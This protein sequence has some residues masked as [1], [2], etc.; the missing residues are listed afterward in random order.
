MSSSWATAHS[1]TEPSLGEAA[2]AR[3]GICRSAAWAGRRLRRSIGLI[4]NALRSLILPTTVIYIT[5]AK[6]EAYRKGLCVSQKIIETTPSDLLSLTLRI[7]IFTEGCARR[8]ASP[9]GR[10]EDHDPATSFLPSQKLADLSGPEEARAVEGPDFEHLLRA[11]PPESEG[12]DNLA[13]ILASA[14]DHPPPPPARSDAEAGRDACCCRQRAA[15]RQGA[16]PLA[17]AGREP[18]SAY[19]A[20][21]SHSPAPPASQPHGQSQRHETSPAASALPFVKPPPAI[22]CRH[23]RLLPGV[24]SSCSRGLCQRA[25]QIRI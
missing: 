24:S 12:Q 25:L 9:L 19:R 14:H 20:T 21:C 2:V 4:H 8:S 10:E 11:S 3:A 6:S 17:E 23:L 13:W 18:A 7:D 5:P 15:R 22:A 16:D 1:D